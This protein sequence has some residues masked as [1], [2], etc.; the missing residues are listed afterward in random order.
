MA[1]YVS[2]QYSKSFILIGR[3]QSTTNLARCIHLFLGREFSALNE[4]L[5]EILFNNANTD[6][7][8][9]ENF[10]E[11]GNS[12][13]Y[14]IVIARALD[15]FVKYLQTGDDSLLETARTQLKDL[16]EIAAIEND[17]GIWWVIRLLLLI[18]Q[19]FSEGAVWK[20]MS[21]YFTMPKNAANNSPFCSVLQV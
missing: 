21:S 1:Y 2:F 19:G 11:E 5:Y 7:S 20:V 17:P 13:I 18:S 15:S 8:I 6:S 4:F 9:V 14:E 16:K 12:R 3:L 10:E